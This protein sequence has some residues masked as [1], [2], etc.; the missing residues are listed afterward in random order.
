MGFNLFLRGVAMVV[1]AGQG[2][3]RATALSFAEAGVRGLICADINQSSALATAEEARKIASN[4]DF[5]AISVAC[6]MSNHQNVKD[7]VAQS[8]ARFGRIDYAANVAGSF[9]KSRKAFADTPDEEWLQLQNININGVFYLVKEQVKQMEK[10]ERLETPLTS[11]SRP[12]ERGSII[13]LSSAAAVIAVPGGAAYT[14]TKF[15]SNGLTKA[16]AQD[17][18]F[19]GIRINAVLPGYTMTPGLAGFPGATPEGAQKILD[20]N[21]L[22][23]FAEPKEI[24]DT[25]VLLSSPRNSYMIGASILVDGGQTITAENE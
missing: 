13:N 12:G 23:R 20:A 15:A 19:N 10:Q 18:G 5:D 21:T 9:G 22:H 3:G 2:M 6:D 8:A 1:G 7:L 14:H 16:A 17:H 4:K 11:A 24:A 25:I